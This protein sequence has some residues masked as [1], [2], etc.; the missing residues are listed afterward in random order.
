MLIYKT[1][2]VFC[3]PS[4][5]DVSEIKNFAK[6]NDFDSRKGLLYFKTDG[7]ASIIVEIDITVIHKYSNLYC[8][9]R[10]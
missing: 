7:A 2:G 8:H 6:I 3:P 4:F 1:K 10:K 5:F 9:V